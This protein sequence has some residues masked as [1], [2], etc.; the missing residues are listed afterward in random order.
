MKKTYIVRLIAL[1]AA[2]HASTPSTQAAPQGLLKTLVVAIASLS[3]LYDASSSATAP[4]ESDEVNYFTTLS[5]GSYLVADKDGSLHKYDDKD[6]LQWTHVGRT[7]EVSALDD[8][9]IEG[10]IRRYGTN[11]SDIFVAIIDNEGYIKEVQIK[12]Q[13]YIDEKNKKWK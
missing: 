7:S 4:S 13:D 12:N 11:E 5:D 8:F 2:L 6:G 3:T 10:E 1:C 9:V